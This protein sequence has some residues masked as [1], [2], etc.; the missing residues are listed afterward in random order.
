MA[1]RM[2]AR[3]LFLSAVCVM[4]ATGAAAQ[5]VY[6][7]LVGNV[8]DS[9]GGAIPGRDRHRHAHGD[10]SHARGGH[11]RQRRVFD[12]E[13][14]IGHLSSGRDGSRVSDLHGA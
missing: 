12:S 2:F 7:S 13:H 6:G 3:A 9:S 4:Y 8:S 10:E 1:M 5:A 14:S 11:Q